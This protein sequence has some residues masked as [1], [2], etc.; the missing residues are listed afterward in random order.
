MGFARSEFEIFHEAAKL[1]PPPPGALES[2]ARYVL[3]DPGVST[4]SLLAEQVP[5]DFDAA[6]EF[7]VKEHL[8]PGIGVVE[9]EISVATYEHARS[10][11][12]DAADALI[13]S[14]NRPRPSR[15]SRTPRYAPVRPAAPTATPTPTGDRTA[16]IRARYG[17]SP[18]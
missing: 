6:A 12:R 14:I 17:R 4:T 18:K 10:K 13:D 15:P 5:D 2:Y 3:N 16:S 1:D 9:A 7:V 8:A 11:M